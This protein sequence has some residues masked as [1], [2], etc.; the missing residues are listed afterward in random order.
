MSRSLARK[1]S[2][3]VPFLA[4]FV[5]MLVAVP[6]A[7]TASVIVAK[8]SMGQ[9][10]AELAY[11][12][13][14][15]ARQYDERPPVS[16]A[17][18]GHQGEGC[19]GRAEEVKENEKQKEPTIVYVPVYRDRTPQP[20]YPDHGYGNPRGGTPTAVNITNSNSNQDTEVEDSTISVEK[21]SNNT[22]SQNNSGNSNSGN[23][24]DETNNS[25]NTANLAGRDQ[26]NGGS[27]SGQPGQPQASTPAA[28][29]PQAAPSP[30]S[31]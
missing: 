15:L 20:S 17:A 18:Y 25:G 26:T 2:L 9:D 19:V 22:N 1:N 8:A 7:V 13:S 14:E 16:S 24:H 30:T 10:Q 5:G 4:A 28:A 27:S 11:A 6:V 12:V 21:D 31:S 29:S 3:V 23:T